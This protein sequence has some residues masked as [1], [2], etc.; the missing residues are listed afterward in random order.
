MG[1]LI[2]PV[3]SILLSSL[4]ALK[5]TLKIVADGLG[6]FE[7][8]SLV[9]VSLELKLDLLCGQAI[10]LRNLIFDTADLALDIFNRLCNL[11][12][13]RLENLSA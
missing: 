10:L 5:S 2:L 8:S 9:L 11:L 6:G 4:E 7:A 1:K 12:L 3:D 13:E